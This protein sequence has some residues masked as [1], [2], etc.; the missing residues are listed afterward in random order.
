[1]S[2]VDCGRVRLVD[3][4]DP[5]DIQFETCELSDEEVSPG[6]SIEATAVPFNTGDTRAAAVIGTFVGE[7]RVSEAEIVLD[8]DEA[9]KLVVEIDSE[10]FTP[11]PQT[12]SFEVLDASPAD[13]VFTA[14]SAVR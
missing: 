13:D 11:E 2:Q 5:S 8:P 10:N 9:R 12:V 7:S 1:M 6:G 14:Q 3:D 4:M